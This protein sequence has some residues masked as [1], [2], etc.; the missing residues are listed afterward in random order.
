MQVTCGVLH[1]YRELHGRVI[2]RTGSAQLAL[3]GI[4]AWMSVS[5]LIH[6]L[7]DSFEQVKHVRVIR[8]SSPNEYMAVRIGAC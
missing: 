7:G 2:S 3:L 1:L 6:F 8:D 5:E 4:P